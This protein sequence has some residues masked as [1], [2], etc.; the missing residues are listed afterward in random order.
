[1]VEK[2]PTFQYWETI[3]QMELSGFIFIRSHREKNF[4]LF[5]ESLKALVPWFFAFDHY[6][7]ARWIPSETWKTYQKAIKL[8]LRNTLTG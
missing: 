8:S 7:Y 3:L 4:A 6:N 2:S 1:M 5:I